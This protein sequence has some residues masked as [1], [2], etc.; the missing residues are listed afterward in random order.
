MR[1]LKLPE[2]LIGFCLILSYNNLLSQPLHITP[3]I[4]NNYPNAGNCDKIDDPFV[5]SGECSI[6]IN[7]LLSR[8][9]SAEGL[10]EFILLGECFGSGNSNNVNCTPPYNA[11]WGGGCEEAYCKVIQS[12]IDVKASFLTRAFNM[13]GK[14]GAF[15]PL[16]NNNAIGET[17]AAAKQLVIDIN[18]VY[19]CAE[20]PRPIIQGS[21]FEAIDDPANELDDVLIPEEVIK[22]FRSEI[23][24]ANEFMYYFDPDSDNN[25]D[26][27]PPSVVHFDKSR[28]I[29]PG[30]EWVDLTKIESQL[31]FY[32]CATTQIDLGYTALHMGQ[33]YVYARLDAPNYNLLYKITNDIRN[34]ALSKGTF[35][36]LNAENTFSS[37]SFKWNGTDQLIFD[38]DGRAMRPLEVSDQPVLGESNGGVSCNGPADPGPFLNS[39]CDQEAFPAVIDPCII[40]LFGGTGGGISPNGCF[41]ETV[42]YFIY[43]DFG[44]GVL[45]D[46]SLGPCEL[47]LTV[48]TPMAEVTWGYEDTRWFANQLSDDC[49][50]EWFKEMYCSVRDMIGFNGFLQMPNLLLVKYPEL[51]CNPA[52]PLADGRFI[53]ADNQELIDGIADFMEPKVPG[54]DFTSQCIEDELEK[55]TRF[56]RGET[57][58]LGYAFKGGINE[59]TF[60]VDNKDCSSS[61]SW[62]IK[63]EFGQWFPQSFGPERKFIPPTTGKYT[64][65]LRQDNLGIEPYLGSF[66]VREI[67]LEDLFLERKCCG[68]LVN[69]VW[70]DSIRSSIQVQPDWKIF[71]SPFNDLLTF[72]SD[73]I[74]NVYIVVNNSFGQHIS[75]TLIKD[76]EQRQLYLNN[77]PDGMYI[78]NILAA[79]NKEPLCSKLTVKASDFI[80]KANQRP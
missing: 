55:C 49:K 45:L 40:E 54:I 4:L 10:D 61:Y 71:P 39:P 62:H 28:I 63:N 5:Y 1:N 36:L 53:M 2:L 31:W 74:G 13:W 44:T 66:G 27:N 32:Y 35:V 26:N 47:D 67:V 58:P 43:F 77:I 6:G 72:E 9:A 57:A 34:Y 33:P 41:Y 69:R 60:T 48:G 42:P 30:T 70:C 3:C 37:S 50:L 12:F 7:R 16:G 46:P 65:I 78:I 21:I 68:A 76:N 8:L 73:Y 64:I 23:I 38:F 14:E 80:S 56:C 17:Y 51:Y 29:F 24:A 22:Y 15:F 75:T 25:P 20:L 52:P 79:D 59:Y 19:D 18:S 11:C